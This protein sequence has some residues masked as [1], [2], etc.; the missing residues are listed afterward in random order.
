LENGD[1]LICITCF[2]DDEPLVLEFS[3]QVNSDEYLIL[4]D[5]TEMGAVIGVRFLPE[6]A[7]TRPN[8]ILLRYSATTATLAAS[9]GE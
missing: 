9:S 2:E 4:D 7:T 8:R 3:G 5:N 1:G 6:L